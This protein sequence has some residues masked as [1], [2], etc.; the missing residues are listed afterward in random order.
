MSG[1]HTAV[2]AGRS[3]KRP[4]ERSCERFERVVIRIEGDIRHGL[5][6]LAQLKRGPLQQ[7]STTHRSR[8]LLY[9]SS[10]QSMKL[11]PTLEGF[12]REFVCRAVFVQR[13]SQ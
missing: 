5:V 3:V 12:P 10:E 4:L 7:Q 13:I 8:R 1:P 2:E 6:A 11:R 9:N